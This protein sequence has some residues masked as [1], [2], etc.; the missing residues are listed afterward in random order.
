MPMPWI[1]FYTTR[2]DDVRLARSSKDAQLAYF[3]LSLLAGKCDAGGKF[4]MN[5]EQLTEDEI[6][7][8]TRIE[9]KE[10]K[11]AIKELAANKLIHVNGRGPQ[12][13]DFAHEQVSQEARQQ[14]WRE[15]QARHRS[16]TRDN[17]DVTGYIEVS[18]APRTRTRVKNQNQ[19]KSQ[20]RTDLPTPTPSSRKKP[21][22]GRQAGT[23]S[24]KN[25]NP[26]DPSKIKL[27]K[28][29][30]K[31]ADHV[32]AILGS[33]GLRN[34]KLKD[35]S[36]QVAIRNFKTTEDINRYTLAA[37]ASTFSDTTAKSPE[38]L[39]AW[40]IEH[41]EVPARFEDPKLWRSIPIKALNAAGIKDLDSLL[42]Q[43]TRN[44]YAGGEYS[45]LVEH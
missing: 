28:K 13:T 8:L 25:S 2:L 27:T 39:A 38:V 16:V 42:S 11:K 1:K 44:K 18:H 17:E 40:R 22:S 3:K 26:V 29:Q 37:L 33:C 12:L 4:E 30:Q 9:S 10:L 35:T 5:G 34:P 20:K 7:F 6:A 36:V 15:R 45:D 43:T 24:K 23:L 31:Q 32:K 14:A 41:D 19:S 21:A